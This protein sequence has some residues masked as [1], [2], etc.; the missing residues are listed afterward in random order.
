MRSFLRLQEVSPGFQQP[1]RLLTAQMVVPRNRYGTDA[2]VASLYSDL[3]SRIGTVPGVEATGAISELPLSGQD[4]RT[5]IEIEGWSGGTEPT[6]AHDRTVAPGYFAA[7]GVALLD[8]ASWM[9][10]SGPSRPLVVLANQTMARRYWPTDRAVGKRIRLGGTPQWREVI[11]VVEDVKHWGL[12]VGARPEIT[13]R[14][15]KG[16]RPS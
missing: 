11:G 10:E 1:E 13:C 9:T 2:Q 15:R 6:R 8:G 3:L 14:S 5:G 4:N 12:D 7:M 16:P